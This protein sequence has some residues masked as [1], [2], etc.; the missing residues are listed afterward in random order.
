MS[1][2]TNFVIE[3]QYWIENFIVSSDLNKFKIPSPPTIDSVYLPTR[4]FIEMMFNESY[5]YDEYYHLYSSVTPSRDWPSFVKRRI[6]IYPSSARY[7]QCSSSG[8][9]LFSLSSENLVLLDALL[10]YR[11]DSTAITIVDSTSASFSANVLYASY[12]NI[13]S[14]LSKLIFLYL[15]FKINGNYLRVVTL[16]SISSSSSV[17]E[18]IYEAFVLDKVFEYL[19]ARGT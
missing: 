2:S 1:N 9:N 6:M 5:Q 18:N 15:D 16:T 12:D 8:Q 19:S 14:V 10:A 17:L 13:S 3:L 11:M 4:S 7:Y